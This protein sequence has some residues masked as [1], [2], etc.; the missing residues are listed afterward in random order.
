MQVGTTGWNNVAFTPSTMPAP[1]LVTA[2]CDSYTVTWEHG[3]V[4]RWVVR[5]ED[6]HCSRVHLDRAAY[7]ALTDSDS[8]G[9][10][11]TVNQICPFSLRQP[12]NILSPIL[13]DITGSGGNQGAMTV[14]T[15]PTR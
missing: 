8:V 14:P 12:P 2:A 11:H 7:S 15:L 1:Q 9:K 3:T 5:T 4:S 6:D 10:S 13:G